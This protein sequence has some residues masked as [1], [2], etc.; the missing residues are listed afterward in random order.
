MFSRPNDDFSPARGQP[1]Y[2]ETRTGGI[3]TFRD[4]LC[5]DLGKFLDILHL[6]AIQSRLAGAFEVALSADPVE[7][8]ALSVK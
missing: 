8:V 4:E 5:M 3:R 1:F 6:P 7:V 2:G